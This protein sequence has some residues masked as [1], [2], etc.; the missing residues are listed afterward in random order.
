MIYGIA[1]FSKTDEL[2]TVIADGVEDGGTAI[3]GAFDYL[4]YL[5]TQDLRYGDIMLSFLEDIDYGRS[6]VEY[7]CKK[8]DGIYNSVKS[9]LYRGSYLVYGSH[10][11]NKGSV[12]EDY[13]LLKGNS[14]LDV[15]ETFHKN[16]S[17]PVMPTYTMIISVSELQG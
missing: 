1:I 2:I 4:E 15:Y 17:I 13:R 8:G 3:N 6:Y 10:I 11:N 9:Q 5:S 14:I 16:D 7:S 12:E